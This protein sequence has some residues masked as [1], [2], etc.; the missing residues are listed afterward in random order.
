VPQSASPRVLDA[1]LKETVSTPN[2]TTRINSLFE[3]KP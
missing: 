3:E 1:F 2:V